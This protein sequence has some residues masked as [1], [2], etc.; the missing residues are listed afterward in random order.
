MA[1]PAPVRAPAAPVAL[2]QQAPLGVREAL[3]QM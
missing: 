2:Q 1:E 3:A